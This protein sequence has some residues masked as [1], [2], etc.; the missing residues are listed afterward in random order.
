V[1][2]VSADESGDSGEDLS[3]ICRDR[4]GVRGLTLL[5]R[6]S[7]YHFYKGAQGT[8]AWRGYTGRAESLAGALFSA[9]KLRYVLDEIQISAEHAELE[10]RSASAIEFVGPTA[11]L[12]GHFVS[13]IER[14]DR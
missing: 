12:A 1:R 6:S 4:S 11:S 7:Y 2:A 14:V 5:E 3:P 13:R 10:I 8:I 9:R